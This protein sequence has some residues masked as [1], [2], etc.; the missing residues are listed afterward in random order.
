MTLPGGPADKIGNRYELKWTAHNFAR[1]LLGEAQQIRLEAPGMDSAEF[2]IDS[3]VGREYHQVKRQQTN[4]AGWTLSALRKEG[5]LAGFW[6]H[7]QAPDTR[8]VFISTHSAADLQKLSE[9]SRGATDAAEFLLSFAQDRSSRDGLALLAAEWNCSE[10]DVYEAL[11][12]IDVVTEDEASLDDRVR[13]ELRL[14]V[15]GNV[16]V[17]L[18]RLIQ[19]G[20]EKV[21]QILGPNELWAEMSAVDVTPSSVLPA[22]LEAKVQSITAEYLANVSFIPILDRTLERKE[23][24]QIGEQLQRGCRLVLAHGV[25]GT[26][27]TGVLRQVIEQEQSAGSLVLAVRLDRVEPATTAQ[28]FGINLGLGQSPV[29]ALSRA[30]GHG[31]YK[32][33]VLDQVDSVCLTAGRHPEFLDGVAA[34]VREAS[35]RNDISIVLACRTYDLEGDPRLRTLISKNRGEAICINPLDRRAVV[36]VLRNCGIDGRNLSESQLRLLESP[37]H[38]FLLSEIASAHSHSETRSFESGTDLLAAYWHRKPLLIRERRGRTPT[39]GPIFAAL[40]T[41]MD[42]RALLSVP[43]SVLD[44]FNQED[45]ELLC[46]E[47]VLS[48]TRGR[49]SFFHESFFDYA[50]ARA[51][52]SDRRDAA[53]TFVEG[54]QGLLRRAQLRR[55]LTLLATDDRN[56]FRHVATVLFSETNLRFHLVVAVLDSFR[57]L[58]GPEAGDWDVLRRW[59]EC[60]QLAQPHIDSVVFGRPNW[61]DFFSDAGILDAWLRG[62]DRAE[63]AVRSMVATYRARPE[64]VVTHLERWIEDGESRPDLLG[65][66]FEMCSPRAATEQAERFFVSLVQRG[67]L[68][69]QIPNVP[70]GRSDFWHALRMSREKNHALTLKLGLLHLRRQCDGDGWKTAL[71]DGSDEAMHILK[72]GAGAVPGAFLEL[73]APLVLDLLNLSELGAEHGVPF[74]EDALWKYR[75]LGPH[76][77]ISSVLLASMVDAIVKLGSKDAVAVKWL[78]EFEASSF[79]TSHF[80]VFAAASRGVMVD[81][82]S[83]RLL[84]LRRAKSSALGIGYHDAPH[85]LAK[86]ILRILAEHCSDEG[87]HE[88]EEAVLCYYPD[89]ERGAAALGSVIRQRRSYRGHTQL[90]LLRGMPH[91]RLSANARRR[92]QELDRKFEGWDEPSPKVKRAEFVSSPITPAA[93]ERMNDA[94]WRRAIE[95]YDDIHRSHHFVLDGGVHELARELEK[96][97]RREPQRFAELAATFPLDAAPSYLSAVLRGAADSDLPISTLARLVDAARSRPDGNCSRAVSWLMHKKAELE[98]PAESL[99]ALIHYATAGHTPQDESWVVLAKGGPWEKRDLLEQGINCDR[100]AAVDAMSALLAAKIERRIV[101]GPT[102]L[103]IARRERCDEVRVC[104]IQCCTPLLGVAPSE[105]C[106]LFSALIGPFARVLS[107]LPA[108][109]FLVRAVHWA[110][111]DSIS[112]V[113]HSLRSQLPAARRSGAM[114]AYVGWLYHPDLFAHVVAVARDAGV[115]AR[116][117]AAE[118]L[119]EL[120]A[121]DSFTDPALEQ[122]AQLLD[123]PSTS[124]RKAASRCLYTVKENTERLGLLAERFYATKAFVDDSYQLINQL[125]T[126]KTAPVRL[127]IRLGQEFLNKKAAE[128]ADIRTHSAFEASHVAELVVAASARAQGIEREECLD[129]LDGLL[130][131]RAYGVVNAIDQ[132]LA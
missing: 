120:A 6:G 80:V 26:G 17:P 79:S 51:F 27:K 119:A 21:H 128:A 127:A 107:S 82:E 29:I 96:S 39:W 38:L 24:S 62:P 37:L 34:L 83:L 56:E 49:L 44:A 41:E 60:E 55:I 1:I 114:A 89:F 16:E 105:A 47:H 110:T 75:S 112:L 35:L 90:Q 76:Y 100:G 18:D 115:A 36:D 13:L 77:K 68:P 10:H 61:V 88:I 9:R 124:V 30:K 43:E 108:R 50:F 54:D 72:E 97:T 129:I 45:V 126:T 42:R 22:S 121:A 111:E 7:L 25:A 95:K 59:G 66:A 32:V 58:D 3:R 98:W 33:I 122:L 48:R 117:G 69:A 91:D 31:R 64:L 103:G 28:D 19:C 116:T 78:R 81:H 130:R 15:D 84:V 5:V 12:R 71:K 8:C 132:A 2:W 57:E 86:S 93:T 131:I 67:L 63:F 4:A 87:L 85:H 53:A 23:A 65:Y 20:L 113:E 92:K 102:L 46:S 14:V 104:A 106:A 101:F 123:D 109:H 99:A 70:G 11:L 125:R 40:C 94:A 74:K 73:F 118:A 52:V